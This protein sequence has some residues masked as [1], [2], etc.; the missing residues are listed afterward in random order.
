MDG[1]AQTG[2][3][4][5]LHLVVNGAPRDFER[6][7]RERKAMSKGDR[8]A[9]IAPNT[10][11]QLESFYAVPQ[12]GAVLVP[13][14]YRL[15]AGEF[16]YIIN[17]SGAAVVCASR[18]GTRLKV[19]SAEALF[20]FSD[21]AGAAPTICCSSATFTLSAFNVNC[22]LG[23][24]KFRTVMLP[25]ALVCPSDAIR[26]CTSA[27]LL[28]NRRLALRTPSGCR[29]LGVFHDAFCICPVPLKVMAEASE[30]SQRRWYFAGRGFPA[31]W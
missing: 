10:H 2:P 29:K 8:V 4:V 20:W 30:K 11:A 9:Y 16:A 28:E 31:E 6:L 5:A 14:N 13:I 3:D 24:L 1:Q 7:E 27:P 12:I 21:C 22:T 26:F 23:A 19:M 18:R 15:S 25:F 17:H